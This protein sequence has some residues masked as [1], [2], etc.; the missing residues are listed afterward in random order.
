MK[1]GEPCALCGANRKLERSHIIPQFVYRRA[2]AASEKN[3]LPDGPARTMLC[4]RCEDEFSFYESEFARQVFHPFAGG[5]VLSAKYGAWLRKFA[6]SVCWRVLEESLAK[7][8]PSQVPEQW[9]SELASCRETWRRY[10]MAK[11][12]DVGGHHLHMLTSVS[13]P[14]LP[15]HT[16]KMDVTCNDH[17]ALVCAKLGPIMLIGLIAKAMDEKWV[18]TRINAEGKLKPRAV[19]IPDRYR[20]MLNYQT[21]R[22]TS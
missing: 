16:I 4:G 10:L 22:G 18:G 7:N 14:H 11:R 13:M 12:P 20:D 3:E 8:P 15:P 9:A 2:R 5:G 6:A 1:T 21:H 17:D 19:I